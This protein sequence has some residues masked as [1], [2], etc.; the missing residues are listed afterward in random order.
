[1]S[2]QS[3]DSGSQGGTP[4][5]VDPQRVRAN[6]FDGIDPA[7]IFRHVVADSAGITP[8]LN[9]SALG[10]V[11]PRHD[12]IFLVNV[13]RLAQLLPPPH[14]QVA[15]DAIAHNITMFSLML[16]RP[17][18][19]GAAGTIFSSRDTE[20]RW[21]QALLV[22]S[23][24]QEHPHGRCIPCLNESG[25]RDP[26]FRNCRGRPGIGQG[27]CNNCI[28]QGRGVYCNYC[29]YDPYGYGLS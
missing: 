4:R 13:R 22:S 20:T 3:Q 24:G 18:R 25:R 28:A 10:A 16:Y 2:N 5:P 1:M 26:I 15:I 6:D 12:D 9:L 21:H 14:Q 8:G 27:A 29:T 23:Q 17:G 7:Q 11:H 19:L